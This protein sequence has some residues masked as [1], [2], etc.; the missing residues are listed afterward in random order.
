MATCSDEEE[1]FV[2]VL[3]LMVDKPSELVTLS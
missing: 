1:D 3:V 2:S